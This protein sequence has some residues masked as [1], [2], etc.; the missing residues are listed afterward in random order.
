M[1][2]VEQAT[3]VGGD[4]LAVTGSGP[5]EVAQLVVAATEALGGSEA[6]EAAHTS[7]AAFDAAV[8]LFKAVVFVAIGAMGNPPA[9]RDLSGLAPTSRPPA[10]YEK[11]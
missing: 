8:I 10:I 4:M 1:T 5:E 11:L 9:Q 7:D 2:E 6:P 3:A